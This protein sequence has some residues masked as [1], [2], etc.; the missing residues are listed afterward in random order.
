MN[1]GLTATL[2]PTAKERN[3]SRLFAD[4]RKVDFRGGIAETLRMLR[5][6]P[7]R[8]QFSPVQVQHV[9]LVCADALFLTRLERFEFLEGAWPV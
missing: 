3:T 5:L 7:G 1:T 9:N 6:I 2:H 8:N 4:S